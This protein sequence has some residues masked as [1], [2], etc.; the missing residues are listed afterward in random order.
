MHAHSGHVEL[1]FEG[2]KLLEQGLEIGVA[3]E[4]PHVVLLSSGHGWELLYDHLLGIKLK[5]VNGV[6]T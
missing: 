3:L 2:A 1:L 6:A 5:C 4:Q